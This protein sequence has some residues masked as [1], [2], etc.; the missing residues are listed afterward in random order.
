MKETNKNEK[1]EEKEEKKIEEKEEKKIEEIYC[2]NCNSTNLLDKSHKIII[3]TGDFILKDKNV[4][5]VINSISLLDIRKV[6]KENNIKIPE[7]L[8]E[9]ENILEEKEIF[10]DYNLNKITGEDLCIFRESQKEKNNEILKKLNIEKNN[11]NKIYFYHWKI[12]NITN[13]NLTS[14]IVYEE[15]F[16]R[17]KKIKE[18]IEEEKKNLKIAKFENYSEKYKLK[19]KFNFFFFFF[20][21]IFNFFFF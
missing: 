10:L 17:K 16:E 9:E 1:I 2:S 12:I 14:I 11:Y 13:S 5:N 21:I 7:S 20:K 8:N 6:I 19:S 18:K 15:D 4:K 3:G